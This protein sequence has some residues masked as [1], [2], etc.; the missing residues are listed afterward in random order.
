MIPARKSTTAEPAATRS[1]A[2]LVV[3]ARIPANAVPGNQQRGQLV[4]I[5]DRARDA[6]REIVLVGGRVQHR[7]DRRDRR[8]RQPGPREPDRVLALPDRGVDDQEQDHVLEVARRGVDRPP[9][10]LRPV[11]AQ[12]RPGQEQHEDEREL[13]VRRDEAL[14]LV[15]A[16]R[17]VGQPRDH[18][19]EAGHLQE[20][21]GLVLRDQQ[22]LEEGQEREGAQAERHVHQHDRDEC[23][24]ERARH[25]VFRVVAGRHAHQDRE[26]RESHVPGR[27][28]QV[29][30]AKPPQGAGG[31]SQ[32]AGRQS[33]QATPSPGASG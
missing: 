13:R 17:D 32:D 7:R 11:R 9:W 14:A 27:G 6:D 19:Q 16:G 25:R 10:I 29:G 18:Q 22:E 24:P 5:S 20:A 21:E 30:R 33:A 23:E 3:T 12:Q 15:P 8:T 31:P 1:A 2:S 28:G 4:R 26:Q